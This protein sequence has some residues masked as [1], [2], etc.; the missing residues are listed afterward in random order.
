VI[1]Q[2]AASPPNAL[3][4]LPAVLLLC[5][6]L[7]HVP[8]LGAPLLDRHPFRQTQT[9]FTARIYHEEGIDLFH[10]KLPI[11]GEPWEVPFEFPLFQA[12]AAVVMDVG[13]PE[14]TALRL[15]GLASF[16]LAAGLLWLL[17]RGQAGWLGA[18]AALTVFL[19]SPLG[20]SWGRAALI[21]YSAL[22]AS[23]GFALAGLRWRNSGSKRWFALAFVLGCIAA[24][25]KITT[26]LFWVGPFALLAVSRDDD[27]GTHRTWAAAWVLS[28]APILAGVAWTR[29]ADA[30]KAAS[31][32]TAWLTSSGLMAWN[33]GTLE[34]R[35]TLDQWGSIYTSVVVLAGAIALPFLVYPAIRFA[36]ARRQIRFWSWVVATVVGPIVVFFNLYHVHDYYAIAV[37][38]SIAALA[39]LGIAGLALVRTWL[40]GL[41]LTGAA[42]AWGATMVLQVPYWSRTYDPTADP[43]GVLSLAAQ[44]ERETAVGQRV[45]ILDR[46]WTPSILYYAHR[47]GVMVNGHETTPVDLAALQAQGFA[48]YSCPWYASACVRLDAPALRVPVDGATFGPVATPT[49]LLASGT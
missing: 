37:S 40:S 3:R 29:H 14:D 45:V 6:V 5:A 4:W 13:V 43:E 12:A 19:F 10:P 16:V 33:F 41:L 49:G 23:F 8:T 27:R 35:L 39:G 42:L 30:I 31:D 36:L 48:I 38:G 7:I 34:Q 28:I 25:V 18:T 15:T 24:L 47:W 22:A 32:G 17:V 20:I 46:D 11:L 9:A 2:L 1:A 21:E 26:A 44:I